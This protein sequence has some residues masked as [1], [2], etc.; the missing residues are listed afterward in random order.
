MSFS[1][2]FGCA[3]FLENLVMIL[4][5]LLTEQ[6]ADTPSKV[7]ALSLAIADLLVRGVSAPLFIYSCYHPTYTTFITASKFNAVAS[8]G[9]IFTL[10]LDRQISLVRGLKYPQIMTFKRTISLV[11]GTWI[12]ASLFVISAVVGLHGEI[13]LSLM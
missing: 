13:N 10:S 6:F 12:V 1:A 4:S 3:G 9:S 8:T 7:F 2:F 5:I 11:A